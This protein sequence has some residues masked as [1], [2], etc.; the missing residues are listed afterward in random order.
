M[1]SYRLGPP[2][3]QRAGLTGT[4]VDM[5]KLQDPDA[6]PG[7]ALHMIRAAYRNQHATPV[8]SNH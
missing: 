8:E 6:L 2:G 5:A 1:G 7:I 3:A 4:F